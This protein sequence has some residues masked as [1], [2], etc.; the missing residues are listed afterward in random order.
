MAANNI[1]F[2]AP[3]FLDASD[4]LYAGIVLGQVGP[5]GEAAGDNAKSVVKINGIYYIVEDDSLTPFLPH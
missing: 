3:G 1:D 4:P 2:M 5:S